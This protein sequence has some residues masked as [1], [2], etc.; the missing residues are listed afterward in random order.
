MRASRRLRFVLGFGMALELIGVTE[1]H[2]VP[3]YARQTGLA[4][5]ACHTVFLELTSFGRMF[6]A[7]GYTAQGVKE[8]EEAATANAPPLDIN[9]AFP[10][11]VMLQTSLT[12]TDEKQPGTQNLN[13]EFPQ[14]LSLFLAGEITPKIGTFLQATY[15]GQ[16]DHFTLDNTDIRYA[17]QVQIGGR[18]LIY[19]A[20]LNNNPGVE[21]L[22]HSTPAWR[23]PFASA[24]SA[25]SPAAGALVDGALAQQV[26]GIGGYALW[27]RHLYANATVYRSAHIGSPQPPT[28]MAGNTIR[29]VAPYWRLAWQQNWGPNYLEVGTFGLFAQLFPNTIA[30]GTDK[31]T[32]IAGDAQ[33]ERP[34]GKDFLSAHLSYIF[35][36][37]DLGAT[38]AGGGSSNASDNLHTFRLDGIYHWRS[39][40]ALSL[41][42]FL[43]RGSDD[44]ALYAQPTIDPTLPAPVTGSLNGSPDSD[45]VHAEVAFFPWQNVRLSVLYTAY[46]EFNGRANNYN[47]TGRD[48]SGN[49]TLYLLA[50]LMY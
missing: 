49:N 50:W 30:G 43:I 34:F 27:N 5:S 39:R 19:G 29:D 1:A 13:V 8:L 15:D 3:S 47:G 22:W 48:A 46:T 20:T 40:L 35:E 26:A 45:G 11:S 12:R 36:H 24:D 14:Q 23:F 31:F 2:A 37:Q 42:Y 10:L 6:K 38:H 32:D 7:H 17:D 21:D 33:F 41:G 28:A 18:E 25:P 9:R 4:C 16:S 44:P